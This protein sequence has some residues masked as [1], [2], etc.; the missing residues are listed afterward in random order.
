VFIEVVNNAFRPLRAVTLQSRLDDAIT[1]NSRFSPGNDKLF[2]SV[3]W[4]T[5][6]IKNLWVSDV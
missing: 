5:A 3:S 4:A 6:E 2:I 1:S